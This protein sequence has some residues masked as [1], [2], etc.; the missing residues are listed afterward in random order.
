MTAR[1]ARGT[2]V[3][4]ARGVFLL[5]NPERCR[6]NCALWK[7]SPLEKRECTQ[8]TFPPCFGAVAAAEK[9]GYL[10]PVAG[11]DGLSTVRVP[12][13]AERRDRARRAPYGVVQ[14]TGNSY[15]FVQGRIRMGFIS[16]SGYLRGFWKCM[17]N[18]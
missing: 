15:K 10:A 4:P 13:T 18:V 14:M 2:D 3:M 12:Y 6:C 8:Y 1:D 7:D 9:R 5:F 16:E 17:E 11:P